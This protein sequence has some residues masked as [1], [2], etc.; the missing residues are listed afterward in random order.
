MG[1]QR[2]LNDD[3]AAAVHWVA[4][5][6][7]DEALRYMRQRNDDFT[8]TEARFL[9]MIPLLSGLTAGLMTTPVDVGAAPPETFLSVTRLTVARGRPQKGF[10]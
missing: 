6:S 7:L 8:I 2:I 5:E 9:G 4:A 3:N 10:D 1:A